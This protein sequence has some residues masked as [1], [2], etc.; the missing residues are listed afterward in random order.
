MTKIVLKERKL[1]NLVRKQVV[2]VLREFLNDSDFGLELRPEFE[3][4]LRKS[5]KSKKANRTVSLE[6]ILAKYK[7]R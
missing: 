7:V 2:E 1:H 6:R 5:I 4:R 3:T